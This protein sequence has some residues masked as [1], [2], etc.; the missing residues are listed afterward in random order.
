MARA[1]TVFIQAQFL[2]WRRG[3]YGGGRPDV[4]TKVLSIDP[5]KPADSTCLVRY[6]PG[7]SRRDTHYVGAHEEFLVLDGGIRINGIDYG[8]HSYGF[9]P[10]GHLRKAMSSRTGT[11]TARFD[12]HHAATSRTA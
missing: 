9:L 10:A 8:I 12:S 11:S 7:W 1:H 2:P 6:P 5:R 4:R 3:L